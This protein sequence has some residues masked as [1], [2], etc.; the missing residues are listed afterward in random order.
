[1][2]QK[3]LYIS[4]DGM[5]EPLG[6]SQVLGYL[7]RLAADSSIHLISFEKPDD[8]NNKIELERISKDISGSGI[9]WHPLRY[10]KSPSSLATLWDISCGIIVGLWLVLRFRLNI[11]HA[12]SYVASVI[13]I[14]LKKLTNVGF[15]FDMRGFWADERV[16]GGMWSA[17]GWLYRFSKWCEKR[18]LLSS[19]YVIVLTHAAV[20]EMRTFSYLQRKMPLFEVITT[21]TDLELFHSEES[22]VVSRQSGSPF[23]LGYV[24][25]V[26]GWYL[27]DDTLRCFQLLRER[28]PD[29]QL[30][31][32][33]RGGHDFI[34]DRIHA[35]NID[36]DAVRIEEGN[37]ED[38]ARA[39]QKMDAGIFFIKPV[40]SKMASAPTKLG[41]FLGCGVPCLG[42][43]GVGDM[44]SILENEKVGVV[45]NRFDD[46]AMR[47]AINRL[48]QLT[49]TDGISERCRDIALRYFS[50]DEGVRRY[51]HVYQRVLETL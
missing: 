32:I 39:M 11:V 20:N 17:G 41:E 46:D 16:D 50:L 29:A 22:Y 18:F 43:S 40:Y 34:R 27:F 33:N 6:Q 25:S 45:L 15:I 48:L 5:L 14:V 24:G 49:Q 30:L 28:K 37:H 31:I 4:Y 42:N 35:L 9:I 13:A 3:I 47:E 8:L 7:K 23:I 2:R 21:C 44:G 12:R 36:F 19:D 38:V 26:T 51:S 1:M 10:H